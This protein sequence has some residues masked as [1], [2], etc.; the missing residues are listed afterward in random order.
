MAG[1]VSIALTDFHARPGEAIDRSQAGPVR[2]TKRNRA[3][4][5]V[6]SAEWFDGAGRAR[7]GHHRRRRVLDAHALGDDDRAFIMANG[8]TDEEA[9]A[10][11]WRS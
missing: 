7:A 8:P 6:V 1:P 10:D 2:L 9:R 4:A 3:Y 11:T 5:V